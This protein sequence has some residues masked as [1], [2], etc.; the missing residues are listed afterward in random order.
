MTRRAFSTD[1]EENCK[2]RDGPFKQGD[3]HWRGRAGVHR[4]DGPVAFH[5]ELLHF[6]ENACR[7]QHLGFRLFLQSGVACARN[8]CVCFMAPN[9]EQDSQ[10]M[11]PEHVIRPLEDVRNG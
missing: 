10:K 7:F 3:D 8:L 2:S 6:H 11:N 1:R 5:C 9:L 4:F